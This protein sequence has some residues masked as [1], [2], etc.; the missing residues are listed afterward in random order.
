VAPCGLESDTR[1]RRTVDKEQ[2]RAFGPVREELNRRGGCLAAT[3]L[4][5]PAAP[6]FY[7]PEFIIPTGAN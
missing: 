5:R 3:Y 7:S 6:L 4:G 1:P 2:N